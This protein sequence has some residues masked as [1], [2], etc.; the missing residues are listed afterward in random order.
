MNSGLRSFLFAGAV[1]CGFLG[2]GAYSGYQHGRKAGLDTGYLTGYADGAQ[3]KDEG[4]FVQWISYLGGQIDGSNLTRRILT[5]PMTDDEA[6][7]LSQQA[8]C[9]FARKNLIPATISKCPAEPS[10]PQTVTPSIPAGAPAPG[11]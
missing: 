5:E 9:E 7:V 2:A 3:M 1:V 11:K 4:N 6:H 8:G 10:P